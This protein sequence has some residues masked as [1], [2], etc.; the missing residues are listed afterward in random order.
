MSVAF[1]ALREAL[2]KRPAGQTVLSGH[3]VGWTA[4]AMLD[5]VDALAERLAGT[6]V[7]ALLADNSPAWALA[8][9]AA[10]QAGVPVLPL[11]LFFTSSQLAHAL[12]QAGVDR[13]ATDQVER[14]KTLALGF[15][16][17]GTHDGL[18][19]MCRRVEPALLPVGTAKISFTSGSTGAP[20]GVCLSAEGL[21]ATAQSVA[22]ALSGLPL[23]RHLC[24]LPLA[25]LLENCA[26]IY[27]ALLSG[28]SIHL[29]GLAELGWRGMSGFDAG[30]L[31]RAVTETEPSSLILVPEL[32]KAWSFYLAGRGE[33]A[34]ASLIFAAVG[35]ARVEPA[36]LARARHRGV[37]AYQ[38][39][40]LTECGS[41]ICLN[42]PG[43]DGD[44]D[45]GRPL[46]HVRVTVRDGEI[47]AASAAFLGYLG[48]PSPPDIDYAT[49]DLGEIK[50]DGH[51]SLSGRRKNLLITSFGR[52]VSPEWIESLLLAQPQIAQTVVVGEGR[53][54]LVAIVVP[55]PGVTGDELAAAVRR[56]NAALPDYARIG[57]WIE[58]E[59]F[60]PKG[61]TLTGNGRP[62]RAA[63]LDRYASSVETLYS[64]LPITPTMEPNHA[65][66]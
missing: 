53:P 27:A 6:R 37:P 11:P 36:L 21:M 8:D 7:L 47:R 16:I 30:C 59:P 41:V 56:A 9:I 14:V 12:D 43:D 39:Y 49:G 63:V 17:E 58:V 26:G 54:C 31:Q 4:G 33:H 34:P 15:E 55:A 57:A 64:E 13:I 52:N 46:P 38:G 24:V 50:A 45:V 60:S 23:T 3:G 35:G 40:G 62:V 2:V 44:D 42:R 19:W 48:E 66:L 61:G 65:F 29:P 18:I 51:V 5:E 10:L 25:L 20:K 1:A 22:G 28:A 32:L